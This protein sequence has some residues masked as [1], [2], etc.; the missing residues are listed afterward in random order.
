MKIA[1]TGGCGFIGSH[2]VDHLVDAGH[3][4]VALDSAGSLDREGA[5]VE[6]VDVCD[7]EALT[8]ATKGCGAIYHLAAVSNVN[9]VFDRPIRAVELNILATTHVLEAARRNGVGRV[10]LASTVWV[11]TGALDYGQPLTEASP[12]FLPGA[13][14]IY[15]SS[16]IAAEMLVHN[17]AQLYGQKFTILRYGI[18]YGPRMRDA[19]V[20]PR[21]VSRALA[22]EPIT[23]EGDGLQYRNYVYV[24][25]LASAHVLALSPRAENQVYNL[26]GPRPVSIREIAETVRRIVGD[27][28]QISYLPSRPG[29]YRGKE[30]SADKARKELSWAPS[31]DFE[32]GMRRYVD[33]HRARLSA[34]RAPAAEQAS[35]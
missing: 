35:P 15:T 3:E 21:F 24:S 11:Y 14:H 25:E 2:V 4:V 13:G 30:V 29:D 31:I 32:D 20:I 1:V 5:R 28:V 33:W 34:R 12:F 6:R 22:N 18:P 23:I 27:Q 10:F 7:A 9:E 17:Y 19:L 26:E 8:A 16:K